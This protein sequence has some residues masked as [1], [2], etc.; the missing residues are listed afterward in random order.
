MINLTHIVFILNFIFTIVVYV[1]RWTKLDLIYIYF[2][3]NKLK[4]DSTYICFNF[5]K[6]T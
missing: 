1:V 6:L 4:L 5:F 2:K 3:K